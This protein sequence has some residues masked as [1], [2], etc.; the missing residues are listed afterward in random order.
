ME[1]T[2]FFFHVKNRINSY[3]ERDGFVNEI[4][5][6]E[7]AANHLFFTDYTVAYMMDNETGSLIASRSVRHPHDR[8]VKATGR[9]IAEDRV[10][11]KS[12]NSYHPYFDAIIPVE[13]L[14]ER[15]GLLTLLDC[16]KPKSG[17]ALHAIIMGITKD[18]E[19][20]SG[21]VVVQFLEEHF[22]NMTLKHGP[23]MG[24]GGPKMAQLPIE[25]IPGLEN[26]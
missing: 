7:I 11:G 18:L 10:L 25:F 8:F 24:L 12:G 1:Q 4:H 19:N 13:D 2:V 16:F 21:S 3:L 17:N 22:D 23:R 9:Q 20:L 15:N 5:P 26:E 6:D 14:L